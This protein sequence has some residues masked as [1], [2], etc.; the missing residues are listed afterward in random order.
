MAV[1]HRKT[2]AR[3]KKIAT[4]GAATATVTALTAGVAPLPVA[5]AAAVKRD[6]ALSAASGPN[7]TD[8]ITSSSNSL[9]N[10]LFAAGN[11]GGAAAD[12]W[13]PIA[14]A[15]PAGLLPTFDAETEQFDLLTLDGLLGALTTTLESFESP[16]LTTIPGLSGL[17]P[18]E[19]TA[20]NAALGLVLAPAAVLTAPALALGGGAVAL[21]DTVLSGLD[22][23]PL[24]NGVPGLGDLIPGL[25]VTDTVFHSEYDWSLLGLSGQTNVSNLFAQIPGLTASTLVSGI[26]G[27]LTVGPDKKPLSDFP[28]IQGT[29]NTI[30]SPL[31]IINTPSV[32][33]WAPSG[34][35]NYT[36]PLGGAVG[37]LA[38]MPTLA[39]GTI[40][41]GGVSVPA[42]ETVVAIPIFAGGAV[43]PLGLASFGTV[44]TPG[45]VLPTA[46]GVSTILGTNL[47]TFAIPLIGVSYTSLNT[48]QASYV[49]TNGF[50]FNSGQTIGIL[51]TPLGAL[52][53]VYSLGSVN[54]G[55]TGFGFTLPSLFTVGLLPSF[56]VG[57]APVQESDD[58]LIPAA[59]PNT[60][61]NLPTQ[62]TNLASLLGLPDVGGELSS[63]ILTPLFNATAAPIGAQITNY[64]NENWG[65]WAN[66]LADA[67]EQLTAFIANL[68]YNLPNANTPEVEPAATTLAAED[69]T[70]TPTVNLNAVTDNLPDLTGST[71]DAG[72]TAKQLSSTENESDSTPQGSTKTIKEA[73]DEA[74]GQVEKSVTDATTRV[75]SSAEKARAQTEKAIKDAQDRVNKVAENGRKQVENAVKGVEKAVKDTTDKVKNATTPK[76][77]ADSKDSDAKSESKDAA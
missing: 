8:L 25:Q 18:T 50:N 29:V 2:R 67:T 33:V 63:T 72:D 20:I 9:N 30:L 49:G 53:I 39:V 10:I 61:L 41:V 65:S 5:N 28:L 3:A 6:V 48:L 57:T 59:V 14:G 17:S 69:N 44:A 62:T 7:Y 76:K 12:F 1:K 32:T 4:L 71:K 54:A 70:S 60:F 58:G 77:K 27:G 24:L 16:D 21:V 35:G 34:S 43:L 31:N 73:A 37:W 40:D 22:A 74:R 42:S 51:T 11:F 66:G 75:K 36:L 13:N 55:S 23:V 19:L 45:L 46:T 52:P 68:S 38:T 56:Q 47:Q 15:L 26:L 64:L